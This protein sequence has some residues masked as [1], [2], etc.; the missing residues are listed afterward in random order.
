MLIQGITPWSCHCIKTWDGLHNAKASVVEINTDKTNL[1]GEK[2]QNSI[3]ITQYSLKIYTCCCKGII[4][5][6]KV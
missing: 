6:E 3:C 2:I 4:A 1:E 5:L